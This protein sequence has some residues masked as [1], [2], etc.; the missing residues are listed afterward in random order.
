MRAL[1]GAID[2]CNEE[3]IKVL[4]REVDVNGRCDEGSIPLGFAASLGRVRAVQTL[5]CCKADANGQSA[6]GVTPV[7]NAA[8]AGSVECIRLLVEAGARVDWVDKSTGSGILFLWSV[9]V[10]SLAL[11]LW[12]MS[13]TGVA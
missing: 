4:L 7:L 13:R 10:C 8:A 3:Q 11:A 12:W 9:C 1:Y 2:Q 5:L 6:S